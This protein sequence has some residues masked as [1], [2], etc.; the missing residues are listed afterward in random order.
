M[1]VDVY[2][3]LCHETC[4]DVLIPIAD[5][6]ATECH[7]RPWILEDEY[8]VASETRARSFALCSSRLD[9]ER[10]GQCTGEGVEQSLSSMGSFVLKAS[11]LQLS[12]DLCDL[13]VGSRGIDDLGSDSVHELLS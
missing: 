6:I 8:T 3:Q 13:T 9:H 2:R 10:V 4:I 1:A 11:V 7:S 12:H 5:T